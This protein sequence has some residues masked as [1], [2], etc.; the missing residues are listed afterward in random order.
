V[1]DLW[2]V[3]VVDFAFMQSCIKHFDIEPMVY[4]SHCRAPA[5][6]HTCRESRGVGL[7]H[8]E[9]S[10]GTEF[11]I[12]HGKTQINMIT[13]PRIYVHWK[14][15]IICLILVAADGPSSSDE[16]FKVDFKENHRKIRRVAIP[17]YEAE[18]YSFSISN[19]LEEIIIYYYR[20]DLLPQFDASR[21]VSL[22]LLNVTLGV[23][24]LENGNQEGLNMSESEYLAWGRA[25]CE[26]DFRYRQEE[27]GIVIFGALPEG[28]SLPVI[29]TKRMF[30]RQR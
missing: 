27:Q 15:D 2:A 21:A 11:P 8:Y 13:P 12:Q 18:N 20:A 1:I 23:V 17:C 3:P 5:I 29:M 28:W 25:E 4:E 16:F 26:A 19:T 14:C 6:L 7:D 24:E 22:E 30:V 10:F 9:L